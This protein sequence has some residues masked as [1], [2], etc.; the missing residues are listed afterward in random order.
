MWNKILP[1]ASIFV[2]TI[3]L[4]KLMATKQELLAILDRIVT[5]Q[6]NIA[7]DVRGLKEQLENAGVD[8]EIIDRAEGIASSLE[9]LAE[10]T[11]DA[12]PEEPTEPET[13]EE[14]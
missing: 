6:A 9:A 11:P 2:S 3:T 1:L 13:P 5:A 10:E 7:A 14:L 8:Q 12:E 4:L